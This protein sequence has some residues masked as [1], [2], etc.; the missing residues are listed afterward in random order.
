MDP[1]QASVPWKDEDGKTWDVC[2]TTCE[3]LG[4]GIL[5]RRRGS[6]RIGGSRLARLESQVSSLEARVS[7]GSTELRCA[8]LDRNGS[9]AGGKDVRPVV[10]V[11][12]PEPDIS[13]SGGCAPSPL[14]SRS[15]L[16]SRVHL[17]ECFERTWNGLECLVGRHCLPFLLRQDIQN[18]S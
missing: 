4:K 5:R 11:T 2:V 8:S 7:A 14:A 3:T 17:G 13:S 15:W 6:C 18:S 9:E 16:K 1:R 10:L 12:Q